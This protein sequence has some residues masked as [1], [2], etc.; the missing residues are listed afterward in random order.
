[1]TAESMTISGMGAA[2]ASYESS[3]YGNID[4]GATNY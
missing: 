3:A 4:Q 2:G 1:M